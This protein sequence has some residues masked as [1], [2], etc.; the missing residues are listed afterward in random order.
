MKPTLELPKTIRFLNE[1][2]IPRNSS[3]L[4]RWEES[5]TA[6]IVEGYTFSL[7]KNNSKNDLIGF[8]ANIA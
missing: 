8:I 2:E 1:D 5:K 3:V 6:N 4:K 7:N